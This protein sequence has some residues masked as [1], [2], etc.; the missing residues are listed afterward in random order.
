M[1]GVRTSSVTKISEY[2]DRSRRVGRA[3]AARRR[4]TAQEDG[5]GARRGGRLWVNGRELGGT[6][7]RHAHLALSFD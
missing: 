4:L 2:S 5:P 6:D 7:P 1:T 3:M